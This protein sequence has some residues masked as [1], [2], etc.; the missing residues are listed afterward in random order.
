MPYCLSPLLMIFFDLYGWNALNQRSPAEGK[1]KGQ[2]PIKV[3]GGQVV[4]R[5][6]RK[7]NILRLIKDRWSFEKQK[8]RFSKGKRETRFHYHCYIGNNPKSSASI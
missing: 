6:N 7:K 4:F 2:K 5:K 3:K 1:G 8:P